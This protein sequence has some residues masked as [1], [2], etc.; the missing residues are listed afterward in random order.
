MAHLL[1]RL[2]QRHSRGF[3]VLSTIGHCLDVLQG[4][5]FFWQLMIFLRKWVGM[6][7]TDCV[8]V[9]TD[10]AA[11]MTGHTAEFYGRV[12]SASDTPITFTHC[13]IHREA[14]VAKTISPDLNT[15]VRNA[16]KVI[17]V[18]K[19]HALNTRIF[20]IFCDEMESEFTTLLL[21]CEIR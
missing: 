1:V 13:M 5:M 18:I 2:H 3:A 19:S 14:I 4:W 9:C 15:V 17:I 12:R 7:S 10:G 11:A 8:G 6:L 21:H 20:A 16:V